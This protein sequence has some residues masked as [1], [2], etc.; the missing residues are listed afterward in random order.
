VV[1]GSPSMVSYVAWTTTGFGVWR[2]TSASAR[3]DGE[4]FV[5][6]GPGGGAAPA[7]R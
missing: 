3:M 1:S 2:V 6:S 7:G 4:L 5:R